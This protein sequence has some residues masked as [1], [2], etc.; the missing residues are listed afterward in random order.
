MLL[1]A[2]VTDRR[3]FLLSAAA[4]APWALSGC[5]HSPA[6][7]GPPVAKRV[8]VSDD[9]Y[10]TTVV[11]PYRWMENGTDPELERWLRAQDAYTRKVFAAMPGR[12]ALSARIGELSGDLSITRNVQVRGGRLLF[13]QRPA[14][15]QNYKLF[16]RDPGGSVRTLIDPTAVT[17][18]G[19]HVSLDWWESSPDGRHVAYGLSPAG[20][21]ASTGHVIDVETGLVL[22]VRLPDTDFGVTGWL[23]DSSGFFYVQLTGQRGTPQ[24]YWDSVVKLHVLG[25]DAAADRV[26]LTRGMYPQVPVAQVQFGVVIPVLGTDQAIVMVRDIR[27]ERAV[28][29]VSLPDLLANGTPRFRPVASDD[30]LVVGVAATGDDLFLLSNRDAPRGRVLRTAVTSPSLAGAAEVLA[31]SAVVA[32]SVHPVAGGVVVRMMDGGIQRLTRVESNGRVLPLALPFEGSV[33]EVFSSEL[34]GDAHVSLE[35]W[36]QPPAI[37]H[38]GADGSMRDIGLDPKPAIDL[39]SYTAERRFARARDGTEIP[40]TIIARRGW[41]ADAANPVLAEAYGAYQLSITPAFTPRVLAF[42]DAG[43][44]SVVANV[45]GGGE[46][47]REWHKAG[48]KAT[49]PNTWRDFIDVCEALIASRVTSSRHLVI[50]GASAGGIAVGRALTERP[51]LYCG[52]ISEV[53]WLNPIRYT[54]EQNNVDIDEWGPIVDAASFR[55][56]YDMDTYHAI[57]DG[58]RY[59]AVLV[60]CGFND[61][62]VATFHAAKF[63]ARLQEANAADAPTLLRVDFDSGH[64]IGSTRDQRDA[65]LADLYSFVLWRAG[66]RDFVPSNAA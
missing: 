66:V 49:K 51:E 41:R 26:V 15:A 22:P 20:S 35:G 55:I 19:S 5:A 12:A 27:R 50:H 36:L 30:D 7:S 4:L 60:T 65:L 61:P 53:G 44:I 52:A 43:G 13:E 63:A 14:R 23:P 46:F 62:R 21:E 8:P 54:A 47:G 25:R 56:M 32:E 40:Y 6:E 42:L 2:V 37:W 31:Q 33:G 16:V 59:P 18:S 48:Q 24:L 17:I 11:D 1:E 64:G 58:V 34:S 57:R 10:G 29:T 45:R 38:L 9:Y 3:G 28:W 39:S